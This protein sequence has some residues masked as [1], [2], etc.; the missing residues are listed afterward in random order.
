MFIQHKQKDLLLFLPD[1]ILENFLGRLRHLVP[2]FAT[3]LY[4]IR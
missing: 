1:V 3:A 4:N 2:S